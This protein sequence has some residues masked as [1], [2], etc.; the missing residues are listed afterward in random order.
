MKQLIEYPENLH[1]EHSDYPMAPEKIK[2]KEEWLSSHCLEIKKEHDIKPG[3]INKLV[4][5][6]MP[7][8]NYVVHYR[9]LQYYF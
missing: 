9:N 4:P 2:I 7:K 8:F 6:L 1:E 3:G 5:N